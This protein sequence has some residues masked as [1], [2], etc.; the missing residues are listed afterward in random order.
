MEQ[1]TATVAAVVVTRESSG[2]RSRW[3]DIEDQADKFEDD[4]GAELI[5][6]GTIE[7]WL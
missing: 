1:K 2:R 3:R 6:A 4:L 5:R 7:Q